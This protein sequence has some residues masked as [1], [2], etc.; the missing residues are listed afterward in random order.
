MKIVF[1]I[2]ALGVGGAERQ[3]VCLAQGLKAVGWRVTVVVFYGGGALEHDLESSGIPLINL[4]KRGRW[5]VLRFHRDLSRVLREQD[6]DVI[7]SYLPGAN[8]ATVLTRR[9][10][11]SVPVVWAVAASNMDLSRYDWFSR[12]VSQLEGWFSR[13]A[14]LVIS[15]SESG[16]AHA[17]ARGFSARQIV[18]ITNPHDTEY[19]HRD[20]SG[21]ERVRRELGIGRDIHVIGLVA[22]LD[23][24]KDHPAFIRAAAVLR[25]LRDDLCFICVGEGPAEYR[26]RLLDLARAES[27]DDCIIWTGARNDM[28]AVYSALDINTC[29]SSFGE[30]LPNAVGEAMACGVPCVVTDVGDCARIVG[31]TGEVVEPGS[32]AALAEGWQRMLQ[33]LAVEGD[34]LRALTRSRIVDHFS[35]E[36]SVAETDAR[37]RALIG[38]D[39]SP[40]ARS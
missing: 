11:G 5:D 3:L 6:A 33:R 1:V 17:V 16:A 32:P 2:R 30:G 31:A 10:G 34:G 27:M 39:P 40:A 36:R 8:I 21:G 15:N 26:Q 4:K 19:F 7:H 28:K 18:V 37:L 38:R 23:P 24:M 29:S 20:A 35:K 22:R 25:K 13:Y 14:D 9:F 12:R